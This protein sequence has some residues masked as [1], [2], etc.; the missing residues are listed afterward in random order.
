MRIANDAHHLTSLN[1][2]NTSKPCASFSRQMCIVFDAEGDCDDRTSQGMDGPRLRSWSG[3]LRPEPKRLLRG[4]AK[5]RFADH[6]NRGASFGEY[7]GDTPNVR[8][9]GADDLTG[10]KKLG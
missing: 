3:I 2:S 10:N 8:A 1:R 7:P 6:Q 9:R 4:S 5:G